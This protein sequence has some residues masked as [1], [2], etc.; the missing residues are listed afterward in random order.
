MRVASLRGRT[1]LKRIRTTFPDPIAIRHPDLV[2]REWN[3]AAP[4]RVWLSDFTH[5]KSREG[6]VKVPFLQDGVSRR[7]LGFTVATNKCA[8]HVI[9]MLDQALSIRRRGSSRFTAP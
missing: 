4:D 2:K 9:K 6:T 1:R 5:V 7:I 3:H 8:R